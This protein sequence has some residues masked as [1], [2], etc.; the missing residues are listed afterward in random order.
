MDA[1]VVLICCCLLALFV[2]CL[3][4]TWA[5]KLFLNGVNDL[6]VLRFMSDLFTHMSVLSQSAPK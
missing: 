1:E 5:L 6:F 4:V 2:L 3:H